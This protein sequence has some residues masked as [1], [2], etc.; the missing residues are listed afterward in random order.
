MAITRRKPIDPT[1][2]RQIITGLI[3]SSEFIE[4]VRP[5][6]KN[7]SFS[8]PYCQ[9][10]AGWCLDF[11]DNFKTAPGANIKDIFTEHRKL[12]LSDELAELIE[13]FLFSISEEYEQ[14]NE[15]YNWKYYLEKAKSHFKKISL[16]KLSKNIQKAVTGGRL[17]EAEALAK[18][19]E[20]VELVQSNGIDPIFDSKFIASLFQENDEDE[21]FALPGD[22]GKATGQLKRGWLVAFVASAKVGKTWFLMMTALRA[23]FAGY[24]TL[25]LSLEMSE[26]EM[27]KRIQ[28]YINSAPSKKYAGDLLI[29]VFDCEKNQKGTCHLSKRTSKSDLTSKEGQIT[30]FYDAPLNYKPCTACRNKDNKMFE[31]CTWWKKENKKELTLQ[32]ALKKKT[33]LKRSALVRGS[34]FKLIEKPSGKFTMNEFRSLLYNLEHY[35]GFV[36]DVIVTD[37]ADKFKPET[38]EFRHGINEVWEGHKGLAQERKCLVVSASQS[39][40]LRSGK[41]I[42]QGDVAED[43]R[44][45]NLVD[46]AIGLN[47]SP[48][49]KEK[50]LLRALIMAL[51]HDEFSLVN[52]V[53][54][55]RC[56]QIGRPC[57]DSFAGFAT[58]K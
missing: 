56:L 35:E 34:K 49:E 36:P 41:D 58:N 2:E 25:F 28:H 12:D 21:L 8:I 37:Y 45:I 52:Q 6:V 43:V 3:I 54:I 17:E 30:D 16:E 1:I 55:L 39:N 57:V 51:R 31:C 10:I 18:G 47:M 19:Y 14:N 15:T 20:R 48:E 26:K 4:S 40:T 22:L 24:N 13:D 9:T 11:Y 27:G 29:P 44:K 38:K 7:D 5:L 50:G 53:K 23:V 33:A 46:L 32:R 42:K